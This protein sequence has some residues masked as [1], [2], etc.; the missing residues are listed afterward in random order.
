MVEQHSENE[1]SEKKFSNTVIDLISQNS[2]SKNAYL[3][4]SRKSLTEI[5]Q[6]LFK[7][8]H[9]EV[10]YLPFKNN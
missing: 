7:L 10:S 8:T 6:E 2:S 3:D 5:P 4:L 1:M 9:L